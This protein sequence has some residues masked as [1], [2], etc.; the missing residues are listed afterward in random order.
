MALHSYV[1]ARDYGFAPNPFSGYC[2]LATCK[3]GVRRSAQVGDWVVG[4][5]SAVRQRKGVL[6]YAMRVSETMSFNDYW[7]D[8][9]FQ[10]KKPNMR[11]SRKYAFGD[12]IYHRD[13]GHWIQLD[14][15]HSLADGSPN[16]RNIRND[17]KTD[18]VLLATHFAYW[19]GSGPRVPDRFRDFDGHES[20]HW[21]RVQ[22][23]LSA[24][25][26]SNVRRVDWLAGNGRLRRSPFGLAKDTMTTEAAGGAVE[27]QVYV[28][29]DL[30]DGSTAS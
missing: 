2:T 14:S 1:V 3:P 23:E 22:E 26:G 16:P 15:H 10:C 28:E 11:A 18:R 4:T 29:L 6:L 7:V 21:D 30:L 24:K 12:N 17:T 5:G 25:Y 13:D 27:L 8:S 20:L 9:R 19:G